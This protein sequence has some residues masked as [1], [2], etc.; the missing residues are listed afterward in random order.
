[1]D[2]YV[3]TLGDPNY[4]PRKVHTESE[5]AQLIVQLETVLFTNKGEV[6]GQPDFGCNLNDLVYTL[7]Y[8]EQQIQDVVKEQLKRFVPLA[9]KYDVKTRVAFYRGQVRDIAEI[10]IEIDNKYQ[11]GVYIN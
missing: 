2:F 8:N 5:V 4:D 9:T 3:K 7:N 6:L 10:N 11:V 1:M